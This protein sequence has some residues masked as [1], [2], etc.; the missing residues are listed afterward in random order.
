MEL[1]SFPIFRFL[2]QQKG[3][4]RERVSER[5][6]TDLLAEAPVCIPA[7]IDGTGIVFP[8]RSVRETLVWQDY[9]NAGEMAATQGHLEVQV[10]T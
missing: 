6:E 8:A 1:N 4:S 3:A 7:H 2:R 9:L 10:R 5:S